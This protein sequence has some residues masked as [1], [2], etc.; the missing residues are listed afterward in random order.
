M[1]ELRNAILRLRKEGLSYRA[2]Q[3]E[4]GCSKSTIAYHLS[5]GEQEKVNKRTK[6]IRYENSLLRKTE[7]FQVSKS[8][9]NKATHFH[10]GS[11]RGEYTSVNFSYRDVIDYLD[12][13]YTCYLTGDTIELDDPKSYSFDHIV[14]VS[15]GGSND[16]HNLGLT[17]RD[18][19]MAKSD[20]SLE[21]F[22]ELCTKVA[23]RYGR[24]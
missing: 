22:V 23:K 4:L 9:A 1:S 12:G 20:M 18:A 24:I 17:T 11:N 16:L 13:N 5:D 10:R 6:K 3:A 15:M 19:N 2:I 8:K 14:P 21:E 7:S